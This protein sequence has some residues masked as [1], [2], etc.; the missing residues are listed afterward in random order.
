MIVN[1][2]D[3]TEG[4]HMIL[5]VSEKVGLER[6]KG[7]VSGWSHAIPMTKV[8]VYEYPGENEIRV[9]MPVDTSSAFAS[10]VTGL[11]DAEYMVV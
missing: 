1:R 9:L 6:V 10:I 7:I 11:A 5:R 3:V 2:V 8:C 4:P